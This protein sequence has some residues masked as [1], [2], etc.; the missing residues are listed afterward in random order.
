MRTFE[1]RYEDGVLKPKEPLPLVPGQEVKVVLLRQ[2][3][4]DRWARW[5]TAVSQTEEEKWLTEVGID[6]WLAMLDEEDKR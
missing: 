4:P 6:E 2:Q 3:D 1:V 5:E